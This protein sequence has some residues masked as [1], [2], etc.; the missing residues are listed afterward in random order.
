MGAGL[1]TMPSGSARAELVRAQAVMLSSSCGDARR[2]H[3][4]GEV[5]ESVAVLD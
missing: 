2:G 1:A 3:C 4:F 5:F